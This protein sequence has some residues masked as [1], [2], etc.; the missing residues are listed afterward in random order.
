MYSPRRNTPNIVYPSLRI[1]KYTLIGWHGYSEKIPH[2]AST[3]F[4]GNVV[5][6]RSSEI[7]HVDR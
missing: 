7:F 2:Y 1:Q 3:G 4:S 5:A 6:A